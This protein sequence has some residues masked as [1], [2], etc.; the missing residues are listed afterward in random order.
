MQKGPYGVLL[1]Y[2]VP[3]S[4]FQMRFRKGKRPLG[5]LVAKQN[6]SKI[7]FPIGIYTLI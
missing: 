3:R 2:K 5:M 6:V 4:D 7:Q 1:L